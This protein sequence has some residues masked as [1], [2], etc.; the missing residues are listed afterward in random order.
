MVE[1]FSALVLHLYRTATLLSMEEFQKQLF[2]TT[3][4]LLRF[5]VGVWSMG[6]L[7]PHGLVIHGVHI[8][9][10]IPDAPESAEPVRQ[11]DALARIALAT[12]GRTQNIC[13][14]DPAWSAQENMRAQCL[15]HGIK[16]ALCTVTRE[17]TLNLVHFLSLHR[18][19]PQRRY[20]EDER[21]LK[22]RLMPHLVEAYTIN[23]GWNTR[24]HLLHEE[25]RQTRALADGKGALHSASEEFLAL[26]RVEWP[27]WQG[28]LLPTPVC[29]TLAESGRHHYLGQDVVV[30]A[31]PV[32]GWYVLGAR[33]KL[34][35]DALS[36][37]ELAIARLFAQGRNHKH[38]AK[39]LRLSPTTVR[40]HLQSIY[41]KLDVSDKATL[42]N[43]L[44]REP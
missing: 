21:L 9:G 4:P 6:W 10:E 22:Q 39:Q 17:P 35:V 36:R 30:Y 37:R 27:D 18:A 3:K 34:P 13:L 38:I 24:F 26:L 42:A 31:N 8:H 7:A 43:L 15:R 23:R 29:A 5:D 33:R 2:E 25:R 32:G 1:E 11:H 14:S 19:D 16:N 40:S 20:R 44:G 41:R 12:P 28:P